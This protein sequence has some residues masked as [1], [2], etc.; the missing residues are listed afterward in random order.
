M[1]SR[2]KELND[3][4]EVIAP[5]KKNKKGLIKWVL[6]SLGIVLLVGLSVGTSI[7]VMKSMMK[8]PE[9]KSAEKSNDAK[10]KEDKTKHKEP[11]ISIY[12]KFDPPFVVNIQGQ[13][14][15]RF[16]QLSIEAM[17]YDQNVSTEI[18][19]NM[20]V[21]RN[22]ILLLLSN[23]TGEQVSTLEGKQKLRA[24][25]LGEIQKVMKDKTGKPGVEEVYLTSI[26]M[27]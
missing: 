16:L 18:D 7:Y 6:I 10:P 2:D 5:P 1:A 11:K 9:D 19:Q 24:D 3:D 22:N 21:I 13:S 14:S 27:Q 15:S 25:I 26:V 8:S 17:T 23:I 4:D 12:Y 20:P